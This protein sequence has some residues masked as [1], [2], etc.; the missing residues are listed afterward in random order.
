METSALNLHPAPVYGKGRSTT[1]V[2]ECPP[3]AING[4]FMYFWSPSQ[5]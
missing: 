5:I 3:P 1:P 2:T 4:E